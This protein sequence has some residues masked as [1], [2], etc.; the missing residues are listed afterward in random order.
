MQ[1]KI[2]VFLPKLNCNGRIVSGWSLVCCIELQCSAVQ[3]RI[4]PT[5]N[6]ENIKRF[7]DRDAAR[8]SWGKVA[9]VSIYNLHPH[10]QP[11]RLPLSRRRHR[12]YF[13]C[14]DSQSVTWLWL[15]HT[16]NIHC[17]IMKEIFVFVVMNQSFRWETIS[18]ES[19]SSISMKS[20]K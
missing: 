14:I 3:C 7:L 17:E 16:V 6:A 4:L 12:R 9:K 19:L 2:G 5:T 1:D 13:H 15:N 10:H 8:M 18:H 20:C 11:Q